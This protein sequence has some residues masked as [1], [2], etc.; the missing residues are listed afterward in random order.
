VAQ[1]VTFDVK[2]IQWG[3]M[4]PAAVR[5]LN[6]ASPA[7]PIVIASTPIRQHS[8]EPVREDLPTFRR[9][10]WSTEIS[11]LEAFWKVRQIPDGPVRLDGVTMIADPA[12]LISGHLA[13]LRANSGLPT[14]RPYLNRLN[15]L[16]QIIAK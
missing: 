13:I 12:A 7:A 2:P 8:I 15:Q 9:E 5:P 10:D 3:E 1:V 16:K 14:F 11:N 4:K 6:P